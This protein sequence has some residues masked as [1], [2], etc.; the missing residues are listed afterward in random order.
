[1]AHKPGTDLGGIRTLEDLRI[2]C[3]ID[4]ATGCWHWS[5][6]RADDGASMVWLIHPLTKTKIKMRGRRAALVLSRG[7]DLPPKHLAFAKMCC[8]SD[9]CCNPEHSRSGTKVQWGEY[10]RL[11]ERMKD[12]PAR[13]LAS[14]KTW[15]KRGRK[16]TPEVVAEIRASDASIR[17]LAIK[18]GV[19]HFTVHL[20]KHRATHTEGLRGSSV[21]SWA[22]A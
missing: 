18:Y 4:E 6:H 7:K 9:D 19:A 11:S 12:L 14:L 8:A 5:M 20:A 13:R 16:L 15:D 22:A 21:F 2:R 3:R 17:S 10:M 1:M